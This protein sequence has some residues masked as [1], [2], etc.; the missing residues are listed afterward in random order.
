MKKDKL[1]LRSLISLLLRFGPVVAVLLFLI[2]GGIWAQRKYDTKPELE[3]HPYIQLNQ[4]VFADIQSIEPVYGVS[5]DGGR[6]NS[7]LICKCITTN[8]ETIWI[9]TTVSQYYRFFDSDAELQDVD[10]IQYRTI[11]LPQPLRLEGKSVVADLVLMDLSDDIDGEMLLQ[12]ETAV[13]V[14]P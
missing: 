1:T 6:S 13:A 9:Y 7:G 8:E 11:R 5:D 3:F 4:P 14:N 2:F 10:Q 12:L